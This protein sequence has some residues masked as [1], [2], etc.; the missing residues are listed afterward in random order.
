M[1]TAWPAEADLTGWFEGTASTAL[2]AIAADLVNEA[3]YDALA[4]IPTAAVP[5]WARPDGSAPDCPPNLK[6]VIILEAAQLWAMRSPQAGFTFTQSHR[7]NLDRLW[8]PFQ[9]WPEA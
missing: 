7:D 1:A 2:T 3:T 9:N 8:A 5:L 4:K 6:R